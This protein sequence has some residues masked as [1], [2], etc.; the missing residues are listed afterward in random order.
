MVQKMG[1]DS[2]CKEMIEEDGFLVKLAQDEPEF[3]EY[4]NEHIQHT[5]RMMGH[6]PYKMIQVQNLFEGLS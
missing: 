4:W 1:K 2:R 5:G 6:S 3:T